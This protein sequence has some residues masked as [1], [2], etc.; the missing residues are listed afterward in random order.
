MNT[1]I[2]ISSDTPKVVEEIAGA[3]TIH[4]R[5]MAIQGKTPAEWLKHPEYKE[6]QC[7][8]F[9]PNHV[10]S[11]ELRSELDVVILQEGE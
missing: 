10:P 3:I 11:K 7:M 2:T 5:R 6:V 8:V 9:P 1:W 4:F